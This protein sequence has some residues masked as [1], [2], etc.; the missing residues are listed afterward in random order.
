MLGL[1]A[2]KLSALRTYV[3]YT[4]IDEHFMPTHKRLSSADSNN[5]TVELPLAGSSDFV[6][7]LGKG[8]AIME[9]F[10]ASSPHMTLSEVAKKVG[11]PRGT[12]RRLLLTLV[13]LGYTGFDGKR[14][15]LRPRALNLGFAY[16]NSQNL[17]QMAQPWMVELV[18]K[19]H[20]SC[21]IAV[22]DGTEIVYVAR[23]PTAARIM[24]INLGLGTRLPAF[25][26]SMGRVLLA[27][28]TEDQLEKLLLAAPQIPNY[29]SKTVRDK[30]SLM[31]E[32]E[33]V[34]KQGWALVDQELEI[35][36]RSVAA[37]IT[38]ASGKII[39]ALNIGTHAS[40]WP[41]QKLMQE[42]LPQI[43]HTAAAISKLAASAEQR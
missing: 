11:L 4:N 21:S 33:T 39:A 7:A 27:G 26:T 10:D 14:F 31:K 40:R 8:L 24:S 36:L 25:A 23:V 32:I 6:R 34:R 28:L 41:I 18:E 30:A 16:L 42:V 9:A 1:V 5:E 17:W 3:R 2:A 12:A 20:E 15:S 35:G 19:V 22:L 29:T 43:K 37:G 13:E 38:D